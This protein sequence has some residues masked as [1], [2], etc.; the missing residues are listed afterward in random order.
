VCWAARRGGQPWAASW[1]LHFVPDNG[2]L[3]ATLITITACQCLEHTH[4]HLFAVH[5]TTV[6]TQC[7]S[8]VFWPPAADHTNSP[9]L[10]F[11][12]VLLLGCLDGCVL[13]QGTTSAPGAKSINQCRSVAQLCPVGQTAPLDAVS[14]KECGCYPGYGSAGVCLQ[15]CNLSEVRFGAATRLPS[16]QET[17]TPSTCAPLSLRPTSCISHA[18]CEPLRCAQKVQHNLLTLYCLGR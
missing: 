18:A 8:E 16:V 14:R 2:C 11:S 6:K 15:A 13:L 7:A 12:V 17:C 10:Y 3:S 5:H 4:T 9:V 1:L